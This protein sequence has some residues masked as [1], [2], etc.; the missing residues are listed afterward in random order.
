MVK[1]IVENASAERGTFFVVDDGYENKEEPNSP[2]AYKD[3]LLITAEFDYQQVATEQQLKGYV[4]FL[5][6]IF[7]F[8]Q[9][10]FIAQQVLL[11]DL[12]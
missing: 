10:I 2:T 3:S 6:F 1:T 8:W 7:Y 4:D 12:C 9:V 5:F 11:L